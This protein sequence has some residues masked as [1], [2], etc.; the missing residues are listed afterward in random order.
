[1]ARLRIDKQKSLMEPVPKHTVRRGA[2]SCYPVTSPPEILYGM[3]RVAY[4]LPNRQ[5]SANGYR[6]EGKT[7]ISCQE[8]QKGARMSA[9]LAFKSEI[10][11]GE[12]T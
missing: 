7:C 12:L 9:K 2:V 6:M 1:L 11:R 5:Q 10:S 4:G 8:I 3:L